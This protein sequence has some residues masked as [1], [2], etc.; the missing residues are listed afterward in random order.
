LFDKLHDNVE[1]HV[2]ALAERITALGGTALGT[3]G[4]VAR[5]SS[6]PPYP[7]DIYEGSTHL[8]AL[9]DRLAQFG[10]KIRTAIAT[11]AKLDD[12]GTADLFTEISRDVDKY[13]WFLEA[14]LQAGHRAAG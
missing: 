11:A 5:T 7:E 2:D 3:V 14:H 10:K 8:A 9:A 6:L 13:L 4:A 12:A 1:E